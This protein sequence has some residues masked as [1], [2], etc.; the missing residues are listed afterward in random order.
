MLTS[1]LLKN[2]INKTYFTVSSLAIP[3]VL[4][5]LL[6]FI[7][8][9]NFLLFH[10]L[11]EFFAIAIGI[12]TC[13]VAW[14]MYPF[15][16]NNYLMYLG[17]GYFWV[18]LLDLLHLLSY[19]GMG[20]I[21]DGGSNMTVQYWVGTRYMEAL[22]LLSAPWFLTHSFSRTRSFIFFGVVTSVIVLLVYL[23]IFPEGFIP[24]KGL[25]TFKIYSE[26]TII[27]LLALSI[28]Y[29][30]RKRKYLD[31]RI[32]NVLIVSIVLT[33]CAE[34]AF[35]FY[36]SVYGISNLIGHIFKLFSF[37][38]IFQ[39]IIRTTLEE[40]FLVMSRG[41]KTHD[42][43][44]DA[45]IVVDEKGIIHDA[46]NAASSLANIESSELIGKNNHDV[47]HPKNIEPNNCLVCRAIVSNAELRGI[48][49]EV[50]GK[51]RWF[52]YSLSHIEGAS[53]LNGTVE[54]IRDISEKKSSEEKIDKL[55]IL[56]NTIVENLPS[57]LFVK[58][59]KNRQYVEWNKAAEELTGVL[60]EEIIGKTDFDLWPKEEAQQFTDIDNEVIKNRKLVDIPEEIITSKY[61]GVRT[62]HT[63]KIPIY[64]KTGTAKYLLGL[65]EDITDKLKTE[66]M[67]SRSQ[68]MDAVGQMSGGI[69]HD[70]N[71]Q[72]GVILGYVELLSE[73]TFHE[74][75]LKWLDTIRVAAQRCADLTQQL[76][77]FSRNGEVDKK[78][79]DVNN[80]ISEMEIMIER[81]L[82]PAINVSYFMADN[83]WK[84]EVNPGGFKD[85]VLNLVLNAHD[86]MPDSGS[87]TIETSNIVLN[88]NNAAAFSNISEG[89]YIEVMVSDTGQGMTQEVYD[90]VFEP[91]FTTKDVGQGTGLGLSMV[92]GFVHRY[93]GD[94]LLE[95]KPGAGATFRI[96]LPRSVNAGSKTSVTSQ[97]EKDLP[98]GNKSILVV[99]D[100]E[101]LLSYAEEILKVWGYTVYCA[102]NADAALTILENNSIDLLFS[103]VVMPG[104]MS[105][106]ELAVKACTADEKLKV[107]ITSGFADKVAGN[108]KYAKYGFELL[109]KPYHRAELA[110]R[111][112]QLLDE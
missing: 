103:D 47:F 86:A 99:D 84:T 104:G 18:A 60:K 39:A 19:E 50:D 96:Y 23:K 108:E 14:N 25:T 48:E 65:S 106:Y 51:G 33:M 100:E 92:Y 72:L 27:F 102:N 59:A 30:Y 37:W 21:P 97:E 87:L 95:S 98:R 44:P 35:T 28:Y 45:V 70:F 90:H 38:L 71:N 80:M 11:A 16:R 57:T 91:F 58:D 41:A 79:V 73:T 31:Q 61:K 43:I 55:A 76:L 101:S 77:I 78:V 83:L 12:L 88:K 34:L 111:L 1:S 74:S 42:A 36:V 26:Y 46:N 5:S 112:C 4:A 2:N 52:D 69:A 64:D 94:I 20:V 109:P 54:V 8:F 68:K 10:S 75:E 107:L 3:I 40:P 24:G 85:A 56:K 93:G 66:Q 17:G 9:F 6:I 67:L 29:L 110:A 32:V 22:L 7:S 13:V 81:S 89:E 15:T 62:L 63:I 105:G 82:T 53:N 49:L